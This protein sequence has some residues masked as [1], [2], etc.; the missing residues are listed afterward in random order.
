MS[1]HFIGKICKIYRS[2]RITL[3]TM[4]KNDDVELLAGRVFLYWIVGISIFFA[5][6]CNKIASRQIQ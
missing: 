6:K 1:F 2:V 5:H 4:M 3:L